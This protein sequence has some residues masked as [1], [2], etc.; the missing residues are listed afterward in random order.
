MAKDTFRASWR[1]KHAERKHLS[2]SEFRLLE[3][4]IDEADWD[5][6]H[7]DF[8][9][10]KLTDKEVAERLGSSWDHTKVSRRRRD[11]MAKEK[12]SM[13]ND[14]KAVP[15]FKKYLTKEAYR[16]VK[17]QPGLAEL[18]EQRAD[19]QVIESTTSSNYSPISR[20]KDSFK[21]GYNGIPRPAPSYQSSPDPGDWKDHLVRREAAKE[22]C[23]CRSGENLEDCCGPFVEEG[24][25]G[26]KEYAYIDN[27]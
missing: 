25:G 11:L 14:K 17:T 8:G 10:C 26:C 23:F 22:P 13:E 7:L 16:L 18:Q 27:K 19:S 1:G 12:L 24:L 15:D 21:D 20:Y 4:Y 9:K 3:F 2:D 5:E 6:R